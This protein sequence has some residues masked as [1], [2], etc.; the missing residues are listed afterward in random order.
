MPIYIFTAVLLL[1]NSLMH[2]CSRVPV[3]N[4]KM[5]VKKNIK[6]IRLIINKQLHY[7]GTF[8]KHIQYLL[9]M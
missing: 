9:S 6:C 4:Y 5:Q 3:L 2:L 8:Y 7:T 1:W